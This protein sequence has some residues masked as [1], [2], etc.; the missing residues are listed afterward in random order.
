MTVSPDGK[1]FATSSFDTIA[2]WDATTGKMI[3]RLEGHHGWI[4][5]IAYSPDG[6]SFVS[7][8][9]ERRFGSGMRPREHLCMFWNWRPLLDALAFQPLPLD[10]NGQQVAVAYR[11]T[12]SIWDVKSGTLR[13]SQS[14]GGGASFRRIVYSPDGTRIVTG[15]R[16]RPLEMWDADSGESVASFAK[17]HVGGDGALAFTPDGSRIVAG[18]LTGA[19]TIWNAETGQLMLTLREADGIGVVRIVFSPDGNSIVASMGD[20]TIRMWELEPPPSGQEPRRLSQVASRVATAALQSYAWSNEA[21]AAIRADQSL[22]HDVKLLAIH[23]AGDRLAAVPEIRKEQ[24]NWIGKLAVSPDANDATLNVIA[25]SLLT[26]QPSSLRDP[27]AAL[28][29]AQRA[30]ELNGGKSPD[31]LDTLA[32]AYFDNG[33]PGQSRRG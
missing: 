17:Q 4:D 33:D 18:D 28:T 20:S 31:F 11:D 21:V 8:G 27:A 15:G 5:F 30:V 6:S 9:E 23:L 3:R 1:Q 19:M 29:M 32:L 7:A 24:Q 2:I 10:P 13:H 26:I 25:W 22:A 16:N 14:V 12:V